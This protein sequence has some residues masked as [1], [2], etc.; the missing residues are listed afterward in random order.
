MN[1]PK[2]C[3]DKTKLQQENESRQF[4][5]KIGLPISINI[6]IW[7]FDAVICGKVLLKHVIGRTI[8]AILARSDVQHDFR[9]RSD[10]QHFFPS[11][12]D[13]Q[14]GF[15]SHP[16]VQN[17]FPSHPDVQH[18]FPSHPDV[19]HC[20]PSRSAVQHCFPS[21]S[22][23]QHIAFRR[24]LPCNIDFRR[25]LSYNIAFKK[26]YRQCS[27]SININNCRKSCENERMA[28]RD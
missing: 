27:L 1:E 12:P 8:D 5:E 28:L 25:V 7:H 13:V 19:Q 10:V 4:K 16:D 21:R 22:A 15:P 18:C 17:G 14:N 24:V 2:Y 23:V 6:K 20:F 26:T 9:S 11:H 3:Y